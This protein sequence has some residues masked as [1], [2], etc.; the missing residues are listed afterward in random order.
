MKTTEYDII[1]IGA[2]PIGIACGLEAKNARLNY[3]IIK[4]H[5]GQFIIPLSC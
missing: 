3:F 4:R 1:I 2:G 5:I